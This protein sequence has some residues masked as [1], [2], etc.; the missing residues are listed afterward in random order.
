MSEL[1]DLTVTGSTG[2]VGGRVARRLADAGL[3]QR[4]LVRD[5]TLAPVLAGGTPVSV[6]DYGDLD[7]M[8]TALA[9]TGP[10]S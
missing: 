2:A 7:S 10:S 1:P 3:S 9:G 4:L 6:G 8:E 5:A